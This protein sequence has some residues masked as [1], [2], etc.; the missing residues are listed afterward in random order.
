MYIETQATIKLELQQAKFISFTTDAWTS[1]ANKSY[2]SL[3]AHYIL[4]WKLQAA[5]LNCKQVSEDH[6]GENLAEIYEQILGD[7]N[8]PAH[9][10]VHFTTDSGTNVIK[11]L[12]LLGFPRTSCFGHT[13]NNGVQKCFEMEDVNNDLKKIKKLQNLSAH[14]WKFTRDL[15]A[16]QSKLNFP[17]HNLP[18]YSKTRWW[19]LLR[20]I[21]TVV[22]QNVPLVTLLKDYD[23]GKRRKLILSI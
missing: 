18:S 2:I 15:K 22:E 17:Q 8:I 12:E 20:L 16:V 14:S 11:A 7:W 19:S 9:K 21:I 10:V 1:V 23:R 4:N 13:L 3:T 6:T 5:C